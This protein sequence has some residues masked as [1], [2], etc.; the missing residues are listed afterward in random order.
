EACN[1]LQDLEWYLVHSSFLFFLWAA[2]P[3]PKLSDEACHI[4]QHCSANT[5][6]TP[7]PDTFPVTPGPNHLFDEH[8][9]DP[10]LH[11]HVPDSPSPH[12]IALDDAPAGFPPI[13]GPKRPLADPNLDPTL[14]PSLFHPSHCDHNLLDK[15]LLENSLLEDSDL[16]IG[17][18]LD[19]PAQYAHDYSSNFSTTPSDPN[20]PSPSAAPPFNI[21]EDFFQVVGFEGLQAPPA[22][23]AANPAPKEESSE[24]PVEPIPKTPTSKSHGGTA[25]P[26]NTPNSDPFLSSPASTTSLS[27]KSQAK[28]TANSCMIETTFDKCNQLI[29]QAAEDTGLSFDVLRKQYHAQA[30]LSQEKNTWNLYEKYFPCYRAEEV[31]RCWE[32]FKTHG[33]MEF[34]IET[35]WPTFMEAY[36]D[37][38]MVFLQTKLN[39][40]HNK[41]AVFNRFQ[42]VSILTGECVN[43][44]VGLRA[45]IA[46]PGLTNLFQERLKLDNNTIIGLAKVESFH[47]VAQEFTKEYKEKEV[48]EGL[49]EALETA[50]EEVQAMRTATKTSKSEKVAKAAS[51]TK[52]KVVKS[53]N[54]S[55]EPV[56]PPTSLP[57]PITSDWST[58]SE[59]EEP[60]ADSLIMVKHKLIEV[61]NVIA[62]PKGHTISKKK[63]PWATMGTTLT[64]LG[65]AFY[66]WPINCPLPTQICNKGNGIKDLGI[67]NARTLLA[68]LQNE[69]LR[70]VA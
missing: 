69:Q 61:M 7:A 18:D 14:D 33:I 27:P 45:V 40:D 32:D 47:S 10:S 65:Y 9:L 66:S 58:T 38:A 63:F 39:L 41:E 26:A 20:S 60:L 13:L 4:R 44:D 50:N 36:G 52:K 1:S 12:P 42:S 8:D 3:K 21:L 56:K 15:S 19:D 55:K 16:L 24:G 62:K 59:P 64:D 2:T 48:T 43:E 46:T 54:V 31:D 68:A 51:S 37:D 67:R 30:K 34:K 22:P 25:A 23:T 70:L 28:S 17:L 6:D 53:V 57:P 49:E 5:P 11:D 29:F 35:C